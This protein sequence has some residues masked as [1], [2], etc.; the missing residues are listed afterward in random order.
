V[1]DEFSN[2]EWAPIRHSVIPSFRHS[3]FVI[4]HS[5][6][7]NRPGWTRTT[8]PL[9]VRQLLLPLSHGTSYRARSSA[10]CKRRLRESNPRPLRAAVFKTV[11]STNRAVSQIAAVGIE[12]TPTASKA[13]MLTFT[14]R[15]NQQALARAEAA[16]T[17]IEPAG[18]VFNRH[19]Q[20]PT[21][22]PPQSNESGRLD[23]NQRFPVPE[24]G[25]ITRLSYVLKA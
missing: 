4:R 3:S 19:A 1:N 24:T 2:D 14:P 11:S 5:S 16:E 9:L 10:I 12:P 25:G 21:V 17:G 18:N 8:D 6:F 22:A 23:S 20:L 15:R 13:V 7:A